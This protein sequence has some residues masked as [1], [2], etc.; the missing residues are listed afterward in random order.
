M[1]YFLDTNACVAYLRGTSPALRDALLSQTP[2]RMQIP[3]IVEAELLVGAR[4]S[5]RVDD[6]LAAVHAFLKPFPIAPF[7]AECA[8]Q[9]SR[10]RSELERAGTIIG[11]NDLI[12]AATVVAANG[13]L[14]T[15]NTAEFARVPG[16]RI[17]DWQI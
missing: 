13:I 15:H 17:V 4:K 9:Y 8:E 16:L 1:T 2:T 3:A 7:D 6:N 14:V 10:I 12:I 11:P 5:L